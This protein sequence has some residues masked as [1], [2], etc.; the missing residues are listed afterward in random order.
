MLNVFMSP[1][2]AVG[3]AG[4]PPGTEREVSSGGS[5]DGARENSMSVKGRVGTSGPDVAVFVFIVFDAD[6]AGF[7]SGGVGDGRGA[8]ADVG[9]AGPIPIGATGVF[10]GLGCGRE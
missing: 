1:I 9:G 3:A 7:G 5:L 2:N 6:D 10:V 4:L 8:A